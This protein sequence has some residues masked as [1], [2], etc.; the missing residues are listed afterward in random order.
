MRA[1]NMAHYSE[2]QR[3][4]IIGYLDGPRRK[5][6]AEVHGATGIPLSTLYAWRRAQRRTV[7]DS[8]LTATELL[9]LIQSV[10]LFADMPLPLLGRLARG[11]HARTYRASEVVVEQGAHNHTV[12]FVLRGSVQ[13]TYV[14]SEGA[15]QVMRI[16]APGDMLND[17][18]SWRNEPALYSSVAILDSLILHVRAGTLR[19]LLGESIQLANRL[20]DTLY[21]RA[22]RNMRDSAALATHN[23]AQ[24]IAG[25]LLR[26]AGRRATD[27]LELN[28]DHKLVASR[29]SVTPEYL[30]RT[31]HQLA[32]AGCI[33][34]TPR[35]IKLRD[36]PC[37]R[38][39]VRRGTIAR[40]RR[41]AR[42]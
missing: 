18:A 16:V 19:T 8:R 29:L 2:E 37:L 33:E 5:T 24:R 15:A 26:E 20:I 36:K 30:S 4:R 42:K 10:P 23:G 14:S 22:Y 40:R 39:I 25:F 35:R 38:D 17:V 6:V 28:L 32:G 27:Q 41:G 21:V 12:C 9:R 3:R 13:Q 11:V 1:T 31:L 7:G 34:V